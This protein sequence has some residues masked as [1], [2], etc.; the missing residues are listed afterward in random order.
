MDHD[1]YMAH[2][3]IGDVYI[4]LSSLAGS[5]SLLTSMSGWYTIFDTL[6]GIG[7]AVHVVVKVEV[8]KAQ[9]S[10]SLAL[11]L[12]TCELATPT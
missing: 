2:D 1:T 12:F 11:Q 6:H 7:G 3:A 10:S 4:L 5:D 9:H 8:L